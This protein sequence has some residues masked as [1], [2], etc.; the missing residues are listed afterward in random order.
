[1]I[2]KIWTNKKG[3]EVE[4]LFVKQLSQ[5]KRNKSTSTAGLA[6]Q[7][8]IARALDM[9]KYTIMAVRYLLHKI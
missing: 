8:E 6:V 9:N 4:Q 1:M 3:K 5:S 2:Y 7:S